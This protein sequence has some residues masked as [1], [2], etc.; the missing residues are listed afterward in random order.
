MHLGR[1]VDELV[2][3]EHEKVHPDMH[4]DRAQAGQRGADRDPGHRVLGERRPEDP[5][6]AVFLDE[7]TR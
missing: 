2:H 5:L 1:H 7:A 4:V 3:A 6:G